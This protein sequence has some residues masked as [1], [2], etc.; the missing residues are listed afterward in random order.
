M[1]PFNHRSLVQGL[2][3]L[4]GAAALSLPASAALTPVYAA[5]HNELNH[6]EIFELVYNQEFTGVP[7]GSYAGQTV[8]AIRIDD[9]LDQLYP[10]E[11]YEL[12]ARAVYAAYKQS[13]GFL[14]GESGGTYV[15][16]FDVNGWGK[17]VSGEFQSFTPPTEFFRWA[18]SGIQGILASTQQSDNGGGRDQVVTYRIAGYDPNAPQVGAL[19]TGATPA[20]L[21][22]STEE[23]RA[24]QEEQV[25]ML[26]FEDTRHW[27]ADG[28]YNDLV[29]Q[30][31][32][33]L[34]DI[35][36]D[37]VPEPAT[38]A[39]FGLGSLALLRR[40]RRDRRAS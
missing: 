30:V 28:D 15:N 14:P 19:G 11:T 18:R 8:Q 4:L 9:M 13:F 6:E 37:P 5:P 27:S 38:A 23:V 35:D 34:R 2:S 3:A 10:R 39:M 21:L 20:P 29:V 25:L 26:F 32:F 22:V 1:P 40:R 33:A 24:A 12:T 31:R 36:P 17:D 7:N 16:L